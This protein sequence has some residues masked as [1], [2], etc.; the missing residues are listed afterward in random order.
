M[1]QDMRDNPLARDLQEIALRRDINWEA[2]AGARLFITGGTGF[3]G[4]WLL[5][6]FAWANRY[7]EL[8][9][10]ATVLSR[11][12]VRFARRAP[13]LAGD[14]A[15]TMWSGD[16]RT[17]TP[18]SGAFSHVI[19]AA[20]ETTS[21]GP[22]DPLRMVDTI[23][24]GTR[25]ALDFARVSG[26]S[27]FLYVSSGAVYGRT[28]TEPALVSEDDRSSPLLSDANI[29]YDE[30]KRMAE[31]LCALY[32]RQY[33]L[34]ATIARC[35]TF[36]GPHLPMDGHFAIGNF[37]RDALAGGPIRVSGDGKAV[38]SYLYAADLAAW[39]WAI[40]LRGEPGRPYNVGS[41]ETVSIAELARLVA[42]VVPQNG[43]VEIGKQETSGS[44]LNYMA[45]S[46]ARARAELG[47]SQ[48]ILLPEAIARTAEWALK[49]ETAMP[50]VP[51]EPARV[52]SKPV[53]Q[54][55]E[56]GGLSLLLPARPGAQRPIDALVMDFDGVMTD[57]R[58][59]VLQDEREAVV[60][61]RSDGLGI[62][63]LRTLGLPMLVLSTEANPVVAARCKKLQLECLQG[64]DVKEEALARWLSERGYD[65]A[66][67][68]YVGNDINDLG[69]LRLVG[70][71]I[72]VGDAYEEVKSVARLVLRRPGGQGA[73]RE[74]ADLICGL[75]VGKDNR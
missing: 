35:F 66:R 20:T 22:S 67:T 47:L 2:L 31:T 5:E 16:V 59:I 23:V 29:D 65:P 38:R 52:D 53:M 25:H 69:C 4:T 64:I 75:L 13:H 30:S 41:E 72:A 28:R 19:H 17:F 36:A 49:R 56:G 9:A 46:T 57:N 50:D 37:I 39:L 26:A 3:F 10:T 40:L 74:L 43:G 71:P 15:I 54:T 63:R 27:R 34:A 58:V 73:V 32:A 33:G 70:C 68:V 14:P 1:M 6:S 62:G 42:E 48:Q 51:A 11:D 12:P 8:G 45:P 21:Q 60:C 24:G 7:Y 61:D 55:G 44:I 18:P